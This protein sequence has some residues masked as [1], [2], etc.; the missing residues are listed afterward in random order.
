MTRP[1]PIETP[2][3]RSVPRLGD[4][5]HLKLAPVERKPRTESLG[6]VTADAALAGKVSSALAERRKLP[7]ELI[8]ATP[9]EG[10]DGLLAPGLLAV[11]ADIAPGDAG[12]AQLRRLAAIGPD[13]PVI[14][15]IRGGDADM[16]LSALETGAAECVDATPDGAFNGAELARALNAALARRKAGRTRT[17]GEQAASAKSAPLV[18]VQE[19]PDAMIVL[20]RHGEV[21][22]VNPAAEELLGRSAGE[23][24]GR[25]FDLDV[26]KGD[27]AVIIQPGGET[28]VAEVDIVETER[29][30]VPAS[31]VTFTDISVRRKL[32]A[33]L[34][35]AQGGRDA[36]LRRSSRFF[37]RVSHDLR[38]PLT[39]IVGFA[40][41]LQT[42]KVSDPA[43]SQEYG[44]AIADAGRL[45]LGMVEDL[46]SVVDAAPAEM[47]EPCDL[48]KVVRNTAH[49]IE[50]I[51]PEIV[52]D[53]PRENLIAPIDVAR[54]QRA[55][56]RLAA[57]IAR[58][59]DTSGV[60]RLSLRR[61]GRQARLTL[62]LD[63]PEGRAVPLPSSLEDGDPLV[64]PADAR[65][66]FAAELV[67]ETLDSHGGS[68]QL[69][70]E[71]E[72]VIAAVM[73]VPLKD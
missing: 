37:S 25:P 16:M 53:A 33:A 66:G 23:L 63:G 10:L 52:V 69:A 67:R 21:A 30:G 11:V 56:Y 5:A 9:G 43:K 68:L 58:S 8:H 29:G 62:R 31:V 42:G 49:F 55:I 51:G 45:M 22:F 73:T 38:T 46:L 54:F 2:R 19:A 35:T 4:A 17:H 47:A 41:L 70:H 39:H 59:A 50:G 20:D 14:A 3:P 24:M 44:T 27:E 48:V 13:A 65:L 18:L 60:M 28:R 6:V 7:V 12:L 34:K 72:A 32:E 36:A 15:L 61:A 57:S 71:D 1:V 64:S 26:G 40:D